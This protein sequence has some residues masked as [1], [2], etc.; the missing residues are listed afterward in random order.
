VTIFS[1]SV[2]VTELA[3]TIFS[4]ESTFHWVPKPGAYI[5]DLI[6]SKQEFDQHK[7][8]PVQ[9]NQKGGLKCMSQH[10]DFLEGFAHALG[11]SKDSPSLRTHY[12]EWI[13][14]NDLSEVEVTD[15]E[16]AGYAAGVEVGNNYKENKTI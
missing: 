5:F 13:I 14:Q 4:R 7:I 6:L 15:I 12:Q 9:P 1:L 10:E 16:S 3:C 2:A 8:D 11:L